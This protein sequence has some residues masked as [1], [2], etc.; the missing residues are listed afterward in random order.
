MEKKKPC[1]ENR[2]VLNCIAIV[3]LTD[4]YS[5]EETLFISVED[6]VDEPTCNMQHVVN[7][8]YYPE[9]SLTLACVP[10]VCTVHVCV[11]PREGE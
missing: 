11:R 1:K 5:L 9:I 6:N 4:I 10:Y 8:R 3:A 7:G 2:F